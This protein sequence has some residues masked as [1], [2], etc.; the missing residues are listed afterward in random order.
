MNK[1]IVHS[2]IAAAAIIWITATLLLLAPIEN[3]Q[4]LYEQY[5]VLAERAETDEKSAYILEHYDE[6]PR[7]MMDH[8]Y[9]SYEDYVDFVYDYIEHKDDYKSMSFT[10]EELNCDTIPALDMKDKRW[11]YE[12]IGGRYIYTGGCAVVSISM[13]YIGLT[14]DGYYDPVRVSRVA[15]EL[16]ASGF[17]GGV[18]NSEIGNICEA[19]GLNCTGYNFDVTEEGSDS[20]SEAQMKE[21]LDK[22]RP[23]ILNMKGDTFGNHALVVR[24]Y[25]ETGFFVND[26]DD[27]EKNTRTWTFE[28]FEPELLRYW[29]VW[30]E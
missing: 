13:V 29:E 2:I 12:T 25:D 23:L 28:E 3:K 5:G 22:G 27:T 15:E 24:G 16:D 26:P 8:Y 6:Y 20:P 9:M 1:K 11:C 18:R 4:K 19:I 30:K 7:A 14:G 10:Q 17:M 21:I